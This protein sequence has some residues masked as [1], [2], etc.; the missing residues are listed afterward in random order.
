MKLHEAIDLVLMSPTKVALYH[1][2]KKLLYM[3]ELYRS[4]G[5]DKCYGEYDVFRP[6]LRIDGRF[7]ICI[8]R[9][10]L[11]GVA[12]VLF[13]DWAVILCDLQDVEE[14]YSTSNIITMCATEEDIEALGRVLTRYSPED[15]F[16]HHAAK[17]RE[18]GVK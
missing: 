5:F 7:V 3:H 6:L 9:A 17:L 16:Y 4:E 18:R 2:D 11:F 12:N 8:L 13:D 1:P 10:K 14:K 15:V